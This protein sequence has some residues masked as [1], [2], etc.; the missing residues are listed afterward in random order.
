MRF[1]S[2]DYRIPNLI[3][4]ALSE[5]KL[6]AFDDQIRSVRQ[7]GPVYLEVH[8]QIYLCFLDIVW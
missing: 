4:G 6:P 7:L 1:K 3:H 2:I 5:I 8:Y